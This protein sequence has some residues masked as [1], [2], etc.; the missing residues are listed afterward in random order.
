MVARK[1]RPSY[2]LAASHGPKTYLLDAGDAD[3]RRPP[4]GRGPPEGGRSDPHLRSG[5]YALR[6][7]MAVA[8]DRCHGKAT[9]LMHRSYGLPTGAARM[10]MRS[11][12]VSLLHPR[13]LEPQAALSYAGGGIK[14][15]DGRVD[16][17]LDI[18]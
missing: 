14:R 11:L 1:R 16:S 13:H 2:P 5:P 12:R 4:E 7:G 8:L 18:W 9:G 17:L 3:E 15:D 6:R 10:S